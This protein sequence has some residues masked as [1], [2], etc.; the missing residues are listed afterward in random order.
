MPTAKGQMLTAK[1]QLRTLALIILCLSLAL[2][3]FARDWHIA[4]FESHIY[5]GSDGVTTVNEH[6][7]LVFIGE[8][9]GIYRDIP[10]EYPGP[11]GSNYPLFLKVTSVLDG[12]GHTLKYDS[13]TQN[14]N[15]HLKIY[16]PDAVDRSEE[17]RV[18]KECR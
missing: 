10:V 4:R 5:V 2:P 3:A 14:G 13:S 12:S 15:R 6:I 1:C 17:R 18:G 11:H 7:D 9:H 16:I 8:Y